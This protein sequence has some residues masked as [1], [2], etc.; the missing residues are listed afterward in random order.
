MAPGLV[1]GVLVCP[2]CSPVF[3]HKPG[4]CT[5]E[6]ALPFQRES[7]DWTKPKHCS[8]VGSDSVV[9]FL[10]LFAKVRGVM[11]FFEVKVVLRSL[12]G[13][14]CRGS[15]KASLAQKHAISLVISLIKYVPEGEVGC[16]SLRS[17]HLP[18]CPQSATP[19]M[20]LKSNKTP[21]SDRTFQT[22]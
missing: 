14:S 9:C 15:E 6:I 8:R 10:V 20:G 13:L 3:T 4:L 12:T 2:V 17:P 21:G 22:L 1:L 7:S 11:I 18:W 19:C 16:V 5:A